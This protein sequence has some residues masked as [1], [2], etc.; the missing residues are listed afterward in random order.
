M[1]FFT[2][3]IFQNILG[4]ERKLSSEVLLSS[5]IPLAGSGF[6]GYTMGQATL[7]LNSEQLV[8]TATTQL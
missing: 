2:Q 3:S 6:H 5:M 7:L 1:P 8:V 4:S